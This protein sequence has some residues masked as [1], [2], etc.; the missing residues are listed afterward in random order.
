MFRVEGFRRNLQGPIL[1]RAVVYCS[2]GSFCQASCSYVR[3]HWGLKRL[4]SR[5]R[6]LID[7]PRIRNRH[8]EALEARGSLM[9]I[10]IKVRGWHTGE[11]RCTERSEGSG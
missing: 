9:R 8:L 11:Q 7:K 6:P 4:S 10:C 3:F 5:C 1:L 2:K